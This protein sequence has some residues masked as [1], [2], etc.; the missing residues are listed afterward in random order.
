MATN[1]KADRQD[2]AEAP[3]IVTSIRVTR[4]QHEALKA[5]AAQERRSVSQQIRVGLD[6]MLE[7]EA[8]A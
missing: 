7:R 8:A 5:L 4:S 3:E 6:A 2:P 1:Y